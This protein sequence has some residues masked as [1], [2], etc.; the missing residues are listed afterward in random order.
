MQGFQYIIIVPMK[1]KMAQNNAPKILAAVTVITYITKAKE[2]FTQQ[3]LML[4]DSATQ[5]VVHGQVASL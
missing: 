5:S 2:K 4:W 1:I 3:T